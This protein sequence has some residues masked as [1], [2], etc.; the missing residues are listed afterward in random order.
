MAILY[1][2]SPRAP[3]AKARILRSGAR[4]SI[5]RHTYESGGYALKQ[6]FL[7]K[8]EWIILAGVVV[9]ALLALGVF[10]LIRAN[11]T[12]LQAR[13]VFDNEQV[14]LIDLSDSGVYHI[15][16]K[17]PVTLFVEDNSIRFVDSVC[18][19]H[20]CE[21]AF[22]TLTQPGDYAICLPALVGVYVVESD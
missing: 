5:I 22:G 2:A 18:P 17:L 9:L 13:V 11:K 15:D 10:S 8:K 12:A 20:D 14:A 3:I 1:H 19:D 16:G 6:P 4:R 21:I 7:K